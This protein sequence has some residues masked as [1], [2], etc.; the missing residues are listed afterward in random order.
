VIGFLIVLATLL[1]VQISQ[2]T[3]EYENPYPSLNE[4]TEAYKKGKEAF[5][6]GQY[7]LAY[8]QLSKVPSSDRN[9]YDAKEKIKQIE[10]DRLDKHLQNAKTKLQQRDFAAAREELKH[11]LEL[12]KYSDQAQELLVQV[13]QQEKVA[14]RLASKRK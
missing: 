7:D 9:Y 4:T 10:G 12:D 11:A 13:D 8:N 2:S 3:Q 5:D 14:R 1:A 6:A